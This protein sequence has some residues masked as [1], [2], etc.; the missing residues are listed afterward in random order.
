MKDVSICIFGA[1]TAWGAWDSEQ[2]GWTSRLKTYF[3]SQDYRE[4]VL[5]YNLGVSGDNTN[6]L[7]ERFK[8]EAE[9]REP[10]LIIFA[11]GINDSQYVN[12]KD[13]PRVDID[14]FK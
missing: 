11:I 2:G 9:A 12:S 7:L 4:Y 14:K 8:P 10:N 5:L 3:H 1:S 13:N 6:D